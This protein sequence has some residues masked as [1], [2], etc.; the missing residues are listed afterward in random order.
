MKPVAFPQATVMLAADQPHY[1]PM[2]V[3]RVASGQ[4]QEVISCWELEPDE[5]AL[6]QQTGRVW[7]RVWTFGRPPEPV[8]L[9]AASPFGPPP[10]PGAPS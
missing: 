2:P 10:A 7:L 4:E 8:M 3:Y 9:Q 6:I 1:N 5:L